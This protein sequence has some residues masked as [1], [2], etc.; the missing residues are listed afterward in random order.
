LLT[1][2]GVSEEETPYVRR[3]RTAGI[4]SGIARR[5]TT[6]RRDAVIFGRYCAGES[7]VEIAK[8]YKRS[9]AAI[10]KVIA[11]MERQAN[12]RKKRSAA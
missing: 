8:D 9:R 6:A 1:F 2:V 11:R 5:R 7:V 12:A 4:Q 3:A 10:Y